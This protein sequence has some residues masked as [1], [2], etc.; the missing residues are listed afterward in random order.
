M[1]DTSSVRRRFEAMKPYL[2]ERQRRLFAAAEVAALGPGR[3]GPVCR[4][5][6]MSYKAVRRG[7]RELQG[8]EE[9]LPAGRVRR[10]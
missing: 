8:Q 9:A 4:A 5:T 7:V 6:G 3:I 10:P 2:N 1:I